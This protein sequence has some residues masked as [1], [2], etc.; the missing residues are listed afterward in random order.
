MLL[1]A[2]G[3]VIDAGDLPLTPNESDVRVVLEPGH[4]IFGRLFPAS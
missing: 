4:R 3:Q 1:G 2:H